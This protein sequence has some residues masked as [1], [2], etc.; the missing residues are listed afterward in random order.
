MA[1]ELYMGLSK[2]TM[3][4]DFLCSL[5]KPE[6]MSYSRTSINRASINRGFC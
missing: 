6:Q 2:D 5:D 1:S 4:N 3:Q